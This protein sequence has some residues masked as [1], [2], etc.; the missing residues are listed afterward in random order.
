MLKKLA[1]MLQQSKHPALGTGGFSCVNFLLV[2]LGT[3]YSS[4]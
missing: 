1:F 4:Q 2:G 3:H